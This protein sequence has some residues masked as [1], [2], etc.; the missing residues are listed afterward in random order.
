MAMHLPRALHMCFLNI[1]HLQNLTCYCSFISAL[2]LTKSIHLTLYLILSFSCIIIFFQCL[3]LH[4]LLTDSRYKTNRNR[5][6]NRQVLLCELSSRFLQYSTDHWLKA[7]NGSGIP[8][9]PINNIGQ[10]FNDPQVQHNGMVVEME[11]RNAG[12]IKVI[13]PAVKYSNSVN[14]PRF[15]PPSL[16]EHTNNVLTSLLGLTQTDLQVLREEKVIS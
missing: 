3:G 4:H 9:G 13:G 8:Y 6:A 7:F 2:P 14:E 5:V 16:G 15:P 1:S 11:Q 12:S 10:V